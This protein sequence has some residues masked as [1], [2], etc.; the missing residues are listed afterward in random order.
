MC[1]VQQ[2]YGS[3]SLEC[4]VTGGGQRKKEIDREKR[5]YAEC[6][7]QKNRLLA[8]RTYMCPLRFGKCYVVASAFRIH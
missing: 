2:V 5:D 6:E 7:Q 4:L 8:T 1:V 3:V